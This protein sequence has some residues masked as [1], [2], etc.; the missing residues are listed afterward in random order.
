MSV[1][2]IPDQIRLYAKHLR[3]PTFGDY[4]DIL[5]SMRPDDKFEDVLLELMKTESLQRQENQNRRRLKAAGF[6]YHKI[7]DDLNLDRY[8]GS[9]TEMFLNELARDRKSVV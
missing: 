3:I 9:I 4:Q 7:L 1:N 8:N 6:P 5:R 2:P